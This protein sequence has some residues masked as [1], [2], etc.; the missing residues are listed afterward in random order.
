MLEQMSTDSWTFLIS[1]DL[2]THLQVLNDP[3]FTDEK[4]ELRET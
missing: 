2:G 3:Q 1:Q 4:A